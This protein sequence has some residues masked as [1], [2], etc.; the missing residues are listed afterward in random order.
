[1]YYLYI[2]KS[3]STGRFYV[4]QTVNLEDRLFRHNSRKSIA[5]RSGLPWT[6]IFKKDYQSRSDAIIAE[7]WIKR[8]KSKDIIQQIIDGDIDL[9]R[10]VG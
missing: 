1:M 6:L 4:G 5:T 2:L 3:E 10:A 8:M 7:K 9:D